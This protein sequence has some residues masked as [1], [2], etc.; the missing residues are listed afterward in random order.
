[1]KT[2]EDLISFIAAELLSHDQGPGDALR[3][4]AWMAEEAVDRR[5]ANPY[6]VPAL[7]RPDQRLSRAA[8]MI[9]VCVVES[10]EALA[11]IDR[12]GRTVGPPRYPHWPDGLPFSLAC[13]LGMV[14]EKMAETSTHDYAT[15]LAEVLG[16]IGGHIEM[17][18]GTIRRGDEI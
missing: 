11:E 4:F 16:A 7:D 3:S 1:M 15:L 12:Q 17:S 5:L 9:A 8:E 13:H 6:V 14:A 2:V 18:D 10:A